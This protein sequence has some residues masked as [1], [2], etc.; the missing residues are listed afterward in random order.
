MQDHTGFK[1]ATQKNI[2]CTLHGMPITPSQISLR[3]HLSPLCL[4]PS[5]CTP[6]PLA[7]TT[8]LSVVYTHTHT[9]DVFCLIPSPSSIQPPN[10]PPLCQLSDCF[11]CPCCRFFVSLLCSSDSTYERCTKVVHSLVVV[12]S[13]TLNMSTEQ[14]PKIRGDWETRRRI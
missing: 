5:T 9:H 14:M 10:P 6:F 7:I 12:L 4:P 13:L 8:L 3:A 1:C 11:M 2:I